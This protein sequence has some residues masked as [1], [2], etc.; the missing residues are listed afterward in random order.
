LQVAK[1]RVHAIQ[2][3]RDKLLAEADAAFP[4]V[5][6]A[7]RSVASGLPAAAP[8]PKVEPAA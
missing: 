2:R 1:G 3:L 6:A 5:T 8:R 7:Y 4:E